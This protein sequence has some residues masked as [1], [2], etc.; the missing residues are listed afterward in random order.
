MIRFYTPPISEEDRNEP[1][2]ECMASMHKRIKA[3]RTQTQADRITA[4]LYRLYL[5]DVLTASQT[6]DLECELSQHMEAL[7]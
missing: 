5:N 4:S 6:R 2:R 1:S 3:V 7:S